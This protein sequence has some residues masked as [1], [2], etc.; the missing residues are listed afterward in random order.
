MNDSL[1]TASTDVVLES[2][3]AI[4]DCHHHLWHPH[5]PTYL[6][7]AFHADIAA[8][9]HNVVATVYVEGGAM[10]RRSGPEPMRAVGEAEFAAGMAAMS[11]S[12]LYGPARVCAAFVGAA[13]LTLGSAVDEVFDA[14]AAASGGRFRGIR[15]VANWDA[16]PSVN[17]GSRP[18]A[19][20]GLLLEPAFRAGF[21]QLAKRGLV[22]DAWQ[23]FPQLPELCSL[24]DA[25][26]DAVI[27][28]NHCG[29][30]LATGPYATAGNFDHWKRNIEELSRRPNV[31]MKL[32]GLSGGRTGFGYEKRREP[33]SLDLLVSNWRPYIETC[34]NAFGPT[35]CMFESNYPVDKV[36]ANYRRLWNAFKTIA[37]P[38]T[39]GE[40]SAMFSGTAARTYSLN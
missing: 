26:P 12:G 39:V 25:F 17:T 31:R 5:A 37:A 38:C 28:A 6:A 29:G 27:V 24:A 4:I 21:S 15:G 11:D 33:A 34:I 32:G 8:S 7:D 40:K 9:G 14:L 20:K 19:P 10:L 16:D 18:Y 30:L 36:A 35:R 13:D 3:L 2:E 22:Y 23:Y 1:D